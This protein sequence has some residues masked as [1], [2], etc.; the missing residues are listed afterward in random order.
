LLQENVERGEPSICLG[1]ELS[2]GVV[3]LTGKTVGIVAASTCGGKSDMED[4][5]HLRPY[6]GS[7]EDAEG[8]LS[9][10]ADYVAG[11]RDTKDSAC[12]VHFKLSAPEIETVVLARAL[13]SVAL[14]P[15]GRIYIQ[16][17]GL[18]DEAIDAAIKAGHLPSTSVRSLVE[19]SL[20]LEELR[21]EDAP[22]EALASLRGQLVDAL[23]MVDSAMASLKQP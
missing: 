18:S 2:Y 1:L 15:D 3:M 5:I 12:A 11:L 8:I 16:P 13:L 20:A 22:V 21:M 6:F 10:G 23:A 4:V 14:D 7:G 9:A 17:M 19:E